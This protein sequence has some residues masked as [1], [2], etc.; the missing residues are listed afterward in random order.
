MIQDIPF[1]FKNKNEEMDKTKKLLDELRGLGVENIPDPNDILMSF[2]T[3][4]YLR[5]LI[6]RKK[7]QLRRM[8]IQS[9]IEPYEKY[10]YLVL[11]SIIIL[12][13]LGF[14]IAHFFFGFQLWDLGGV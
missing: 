4:M 8:K 9:M 10:I 7:S 12:C 1:S 5:I 14:L 2:F 11:V 13:F 3:R 6:S